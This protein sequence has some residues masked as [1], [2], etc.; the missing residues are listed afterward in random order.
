MSLVLVNR[1]LILV[2]HSAPSPT[3]ASPLYLFA[4]YRK[5]ITEPEPG[6]LPFKRPKL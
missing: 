5:Q 6:K 4:D 3:P 2:L 1:I